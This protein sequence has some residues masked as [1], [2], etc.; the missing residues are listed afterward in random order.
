MQSSKLYELQEWFPDL[1]IVEPWRRYIS[2]REML[3]LV[4]S[5]Q[6]PMMVYFLTDLILVC[7]SRY[8]MHKLLTL[9]DRCNC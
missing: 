1:P 5:D 6:V 7:E 8:K 3:V 9:K 2:G 4:G